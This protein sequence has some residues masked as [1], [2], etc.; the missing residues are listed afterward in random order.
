MLPRCGV[1]GKT[2][3]RCPDRQLT[4]PAQHPRRKIIDRT[5]EAIALAHREPSPV[6]ITNGL[7]AAIWRA[8]LRHPQ[9]WGSPAVQRF[10]AR[11]QHQDHSRKEQHRE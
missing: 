5:A 10:I 8:I 1:C 4:H 7:D 3:C 6:R 11:H 9:H 2:R